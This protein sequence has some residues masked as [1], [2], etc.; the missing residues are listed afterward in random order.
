MKDH[1]GSTALHLAC[2]RGNI[3]AVNIMLLSHSNIIE[4]LKTT[5][6]NKETPLHEA[7]L[8]KHLEVV[9]KIIDAV[10]DVEQDSLSEIIV[11]QNSE[12]KT[13]LHVACQEGHSE[14][15]GYILKKSGDC[16][17]RLTKIVDNEKNQAFHLACESGKIDAVKVFIKEANEFVS[18]KDCNEAGYCPL[19]IAAYQ[20]YEELAAILIEGKTG[21]D[22]FD[23]FEVNIC[24]RSNQ[25][26]LHHAAR[27]GHVELVKFL[28][29]K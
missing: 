28:L 10:I 8:N 7:C 12:N 19:H 24:D 11:A 5:N 14:I 21:G 29:G 13:P 23:C 6:L 18:S 9:K 26:P 4:L 1:Q 16:K 2:R 15:V 3:N 17:H 27:N 22:T 25:T 20:G